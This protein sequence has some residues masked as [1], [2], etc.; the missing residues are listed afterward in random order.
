MDIKSLCHNFDVFQENFDKMQVNTNI[1]N[2]NFDKLNSDSN[3]VQNANNLFEQ[4]KNDVVYAE[5]KNNGNV[6]LNTE[7]VK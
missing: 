1:M 3:T 6:V 2:E 7:A 5:T 4:I